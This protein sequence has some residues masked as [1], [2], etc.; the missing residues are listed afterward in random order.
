MFVAHEAKPVSLGFRPAELV[1]GHPMHG[2][3]NV[4]SIWKYNSLFHEL[5]HF[6]CDL[7]KEILCKSQT[8]LIE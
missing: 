7:A 1:F 5:W 8:N 4:K 6:A 2:P 3:L